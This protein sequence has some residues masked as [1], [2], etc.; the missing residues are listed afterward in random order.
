[1]QYKEREEHE[2]LNVKVYTPNRKVIACGILCRNLN[3]KHAEIYD[4]LTSMDF[5]SILSLYM[6]SNA[7]L[8]M[9]YVLFHTCLLSL[10]ERMYALCLRNWPLTR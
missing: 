2:K 8:I 1:M 5:I 9:C 4:I 6:Q 10:L 3:G 7:Q